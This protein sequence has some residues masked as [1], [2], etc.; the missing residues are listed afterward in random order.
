M[1]RDCSLPY[2][3][4][5][6]G[7]GKREGFIPFSCLCKS[8]CNKQE[9]KLGLPIS[10]SKPTSHLTICTSHLHSLSSSCF[11]HC[12]SHLQGISNLILCLIYGDEI[13]LVPCLR[14]LNFVLISAQHQFFVFCL[15]RTLSSASELLSIDQTC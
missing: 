1:V 9:F 10:Y 3:T 14:I 13:V 5:C 12:V 2:L 6:W 15:E 8:E 4:H 11:G 7:G